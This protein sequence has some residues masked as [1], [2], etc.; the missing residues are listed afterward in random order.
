MKRRWSWLGLCAVLL[1]AASV[2]A[3]EA[4]TEHKWEAGKCSILFPGKPKELTNKSTN[5]D[6]TP[7]E[8]HMI[9][10]EGGGGKHV[11]LVAYT[12]NAALANAS[13]ELKEKA[14]DGGRDAAAKSIQGKLVPDKEK[15]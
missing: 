9:M 7:V 11:Y 12:P 5:P 14:L 15:K 3:G 8:T 2:T 13:D 4:W 6:G 10:I 1:S